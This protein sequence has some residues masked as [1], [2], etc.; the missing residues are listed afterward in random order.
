M[1]FVKFLLDLSQFSFCFSLLIHFLRRFL[2]SFDFIFRFPT[3]LSLWIILSYLKVCLF[4]LIWL[5]I[6][7]FTFINILRI[8]LNWIFF[9]NCGLNLFFLLFRNVV[10]VTEGQIRSTV[11]INVVNA[12]YHLLVLF[13]VH[14]IDQFNIITGFWILSVELE[15]DVFVTVENKII[16]TIRVSLR[17]VHNIP[18]FSKIFVIEPEH[19]VKFIQIGS[20]RVTMRLTLFVQ[21]GDEI[22]ASFLFVHHSILSIIMIAWC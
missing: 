1:P 13:F 9:L 19:G 21:F 2:I 15:A 7:C 6:S 12:P 4:R 5:R 18:S 22:T 16:I 20:Q 10:N 11:G 14:F 3:E 17:L 8:K